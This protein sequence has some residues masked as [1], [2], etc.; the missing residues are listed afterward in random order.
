MPD[1]VTYRPATA[2]DIEATYE[3][4]RNATGDLLAQRNLALAEPTAAGRARFFAFRRHVLRHDP[5]RFWVAES[6]RDRQ[7]VGFGIATLRDRL[8]YLAAL[9]VRPGWQ[10]RGIGRDLLRRCQESIAVR[11]EIVRI[12]ISDSLNPHSNLLYARAG[13]MQSEA[14]IVLSGPTYAADSRLTVARIDCAD[15]MTEFDLAA[16]GTTR[17]QDH[18]F[19]LEQ[20]SQSLLTMTNA[21]AVVGYAYAGAAGVGPAVGRD[22]ATLATV[23]D[24]AIGW[25]HA[26]GQV[27]ASL[28]L[29]GS[30][31]ASLALL[32]SRGFRY[33]H[34]L[35]I[36]NSAPM[37]NL[38]R[39]AVS[40]AD[41]LF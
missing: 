34:M 41:A 7:L 4:F 13:M 12:V 1:A 26:G 11:P 40:V 10:G 2:A 36:G 17:G 35:L 31:R 38:D 6:G 28:K 37:P 30:A 8:W 39:Y 9:H 18:A 23:I 25:L 24:A 5:D 33:D 32:L 22:E 3:L 29:P 14:L 19:W 27:N 15:S 21:D 20:P 16:L